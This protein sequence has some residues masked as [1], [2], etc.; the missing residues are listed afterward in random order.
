MRKEALI[1]ESKK[2]L[3]DYVV[4]NSDNYPRLGK[5]VAS[6]ILAAPLN[7]QLL[8]GIAAGQIK[9]SEIINACADHFRKQKYLEKNLS[10]DKLM[11]D[12]SSG[13]LAKSAVNKIVEPIKK[14]SEAKVKKNIE[15]ERK[16]QKN[17][18]AGRMS[19]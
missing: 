8:Q 2:A 5:V 3:D 7:R 19:M 1:S 11:A 9:E 12:I 14:A 18:N 13:K 15:N 10:M 4:S 17:V 6:Q 16:Q